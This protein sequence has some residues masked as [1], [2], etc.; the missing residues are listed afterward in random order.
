MEAQGPHLPL[1]PGNWA[2]GLCRTPAAPHIDTLRETLGEGWKGE[3]WASAVTHCSAEWR[4]RSGRWGQWAGFG[5]G[6]YRAEPFG[7]WGGLQFIRFPL[8]YNSLRLL[9]NFPYRSLPAPPDWWRGVARL[10]LSALRR[11]K[12]KGKLPT[13]FFLLGPWAGEHW[14]PGRLPQSRAKVPRVGNS[15]RGRDGQGQ[16]ILTMARWNFLICL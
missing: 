1:A 13:Y 8:D 6:T 12:G 9:P 11:L 10:S 16:S 7:L 5:I 3:S 15:R 4:H 2:N 14:L